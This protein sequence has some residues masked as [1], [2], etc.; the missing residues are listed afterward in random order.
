V[1]RDRDAVCVPREVVQHVSGTAKRRL[2][3][4]DPRL[5]MERSEPRAKGGL[6]GQHL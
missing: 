6:R 4:D 2:R 1:I 5:M 3:L